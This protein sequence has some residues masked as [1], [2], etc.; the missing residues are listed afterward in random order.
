MPLSWIEQR[1]AERARRIEQLVQPKAQQQAADQVSIGN[2]IGSLRVPVGIDWREF[3]ETMSLVEQTLREDPAGVYAQMDF[4]TR[5]H[6]RHVV[7][8]LARRCPHSEIEVAET[9]LRLARAE[10]AS[11]PGARSNHVGY[12]LIDKGRAKLE[13]EIGLLGNNEISSRVTTEFN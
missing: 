10:A 2:S 8:A 9:A 13:S 12:F 3:V 11:H 4:A 7:E 1:L 6:Y 5:D